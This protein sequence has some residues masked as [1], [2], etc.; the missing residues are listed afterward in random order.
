[1]KRTTTIMA[2]W[3]I[4]GGMLLA[5][6]TASAE[7]KKG[8]VVDLT[9][10][11]K[12]RV[13]E[14][15]TPNKSAVSVEIYQNPDNKPTGDIQ[16][17]YVYTVN[18]VDFSVESL[19]SN[20]FANN[21]DLTSITF[22]NAGITSIPSRAFYAC[23]SLKKFDFTGIKYLSDQAFMDSGLTE[24]IM[25]DV[26]NIG[27][28][29]F[30][31]C[32]SLT[33]IEIGEGCR[34]IGGMATGLCGELKEAILHYGL[35]EIGV[36]NFSFSL[37]LNDFVLPYTVTSITKDLTAN[38]A[39]KRVFILSPKFKD[40]CQPEEEG[41]KPVGLSLVDHST[42][43]DVY[44]LDELVDDVNNLLTYS[45]RANGI[46][47]KSVSEFVE[48]VPVMGEEGKF[49]I[50]KH[51]ED[52]HFVEVYKSNGT[53]RL[54]ADNDGVFTTTDGKAQ[55]VYT[56]DKINE[57]RYQVEIDNGYPVS[58]EQVVKMY[59]D[60]FTGTWDDSD[61]TREEGL[62]VKKDVTVKSGEFLIK[63]FENAEST[64]PL[65]IKSVNADGEVTVG[66]D[67][68]GA[69][70]GCNWKIQ[71]GTYTFTFNP[72]TYILNVTGEVDTTP[73]P[74]PVW[75]Y[76]LHGNIEN[77]TDW[78]DITLTETDGLWS[79]VV[80][81][82]AGGEFGIKS[83]DT[84]NNKQGPWISALKGEADGP[85]E[86]VVGEEMKAATSD[87][88]NWSIGE[89]SFT[90]TYNP[91]EE[92]LIVEKVESE[93]PVPDPEYVY[94]MCGKT[95]DDGEW[96]D[97]PMDGNDGLWTLT[98][99]EGFVEF[100]IKEYDKTVSMEETTE[101]IKSEGE[102]SIEEKGEYPASAEGTFNWVSILV[103]E[104]TYIFDPESMTL[105]VD[106]S[107][108]I[109]S[110]EAAEGEAI[111]FNLKGERIAAPMKGVSIR[112]LDGKARKI[113]K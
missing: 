37:A 35:T 7:Y 24:A 97:Y 36:N 11:L 103:K 73:D 12:G 80:T 45:E 6:A 89:G 2:K 98:L 10:T 90:I 64:T 53:D 18:S 61:M 9:P 19:A 21:R 99:D 88:V 28:Q 34:I 102:V 82:I 3:L 76:T 100:Y 49:T 81:D 111:Y 31:Y 72:A 85:V 95:T 29:A 77:G 26:W 4:C 15:Q 60:I 1:M 68:A 30:A 91:Q 109:S 71:K 84:A 94:V 93:E 8:D 25:K 14:D 63:I 56:V 58:E 5:S 22:N 74:E 42:L 46:K 79:A 17:K 41:Q 27:N 20:A 57:L 38:S 51:D 16:L 101:V 48:V 33:R 69:T 50:V 104:T 39:V 52:I 112:V 108:G 75:E 32:N 43:T 105:T 55:L 107:T 54:Y 47:A 106:G 86:V 13:I 78:K 65:Y 40:Y 67:N 110:V 44:T 92:T 62:W 70:E 83:Y 113:M 66:G 87:N 59:G 96:E 23:T